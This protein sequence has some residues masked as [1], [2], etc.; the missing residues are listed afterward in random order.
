MKRIFTLIVSLL[1]TFLPLTAMSETWNMATN[2]PDFAFHTVNIRMFA[3]DIKKATN[4]NLEIKVH[5]AQSLIKHPEIKN[6]VRSGQVPLGEIILSRLSNENA[7]YEADGIP[8]M[9]SNY[10]EAQQLWDAQRPFVEKL[11]AQQGIRVLYSVPW[12]PQGLFTK[13]AI[14][15]ANDLKSMRIRTYSKTTERLAALL[16][17][18]STQTEATEMA[19]AFLTGRVDAMIT[20]PVTGASNQAWEWITHYYDIQANLPK[21]IVFVNENSFQKLDKTTQNVLLEAARTANDRGWKMSM[22]DAQKGVDD[23]KAHGVKGITPSASLTK[24]FKDVGVTMSK[25]WAV[26]AGK[27]GQELL[28]AYNALRS[29][30]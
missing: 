18:A 17:M 4:G 6:A 21:N 14:E 30:K 2:Y 15:S 19:T 22:V 26:A 27:P 11:F 23:L 1:V 20:S 13:K 12:H 16:G 9:A 7:L 25:E 3:D 8:F 24:S 5:S 29:K 28:D 10:T